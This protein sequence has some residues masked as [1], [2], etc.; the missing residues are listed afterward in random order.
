MDPVYIVGVGMSRFESEKPADTFADLVYEATANALDDAGLTW[1]DLESVVTVSNDFMDGRTISSMPVMHACGSYGKNVS[2]VE[3][4]G[5]FGAIYGMMRVLSGKYGSTLVVAHSKGS[6]GSPACITNGMFDPIYER[7]LGID[8]ISSSAMQARVYMDRFGITEEQCAQV[9]V[10]N[11][12][13]AI[14]NPFALRAK[15]ISVDEVMRSKMMAD[16]IKELDASPITDGSCAIIFASQDF[17]KKTKTKPV[18]P[19]GLGYCADAYFI[20]DRDLS[21]SASL[22]KAAQTAYQMAGIKDPLGE[23]DVAEISETFTYQELMWTEGL[24]FCEPGKG[25]A[26]LEAGTTGMGGKL[27]VNPSGGLLAANATLVA[28]LVRI[29]EIIRQL[30]G[31]AGNHQVD[32]ARLGLAHGVNGVC[33]QAHCVWI[34]GTD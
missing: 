34:F 20:G 5:T 1:E 19:L 33:G 24:G 10:K 9:S 23:L 25:A 26:L 27:P 17:V 22:S 16:P 7:M 14:D 2:T 21:Q 32:N 13:N 3:G 29:A 15:E 11:L 31:E 8:F 4:D 30:R 12:K 6:E 18:R 28:G